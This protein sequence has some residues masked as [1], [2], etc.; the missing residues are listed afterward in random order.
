MAC[1]DRPK[2][3][4]AAVTD[5]AECSFRRQAS[6]SLEFIGNRRRS[7][8]RRRCGACAPQPTTI[9][10]APAPATGRISSNGYQWM[11]SGTAPQ[12]A[13]TSQRCA[14]SK[15]RSSLGKELWL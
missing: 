5:P 15:I 6:H 12:T 11:E 3:A 7:K 13:S 10:Y 9:P 14:K 2:T 4:I 8:T 1:C